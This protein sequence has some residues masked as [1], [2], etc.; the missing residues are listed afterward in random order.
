MP[1]HRPAI[2][3]GERWDCVDVAD[4]AEGA[5]GIAGSKVVVGWDLDVDVLAF[6]GAGEGITVEDDG[7]VEMSTTRLGSAVVASRARCFC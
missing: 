2:A 5:I 1:M 7:A 6:V 3:A 4:D